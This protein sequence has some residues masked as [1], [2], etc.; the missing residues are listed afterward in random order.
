MLSNHARQSGRPS[1]CRA[2]SWGRVGDQFLVGQIHEAKRATK[3][4]PS[5]LARRSRRPSPCRAT[6]R[7]RAS[8]Q[9]SCRATLQ[10]GAGDQVLTKQPCVAECATKCMLRNLVR[11]NEWPSP[12][13]STGSRTILTSVREGWLNDTSPHQQDK[14]GHHQTT[15]EPRVCRQKVPNRCQTT[16]VVYCPKQTPQASVQSTPVEGISA[17]ESLQ[18]PE[19]RKGCNGY[20]IP[21]YAYACQ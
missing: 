14:T 8:D 11:R 6:L 9:S 12:R 19:C 4:L 7:G 18:W 2:N 13:R 16:L 20:P 15:S 5:G 10:G 21:V 3:S 17:S 1:R